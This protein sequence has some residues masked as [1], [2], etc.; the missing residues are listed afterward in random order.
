[1]KPTDEDVVVMDN[2]RPHTWSKARRL[3]LCTAASVVVLC[4][5]CRVLTNRLVTLETQRAPRDPETGI[6]VGAEPRD[7][8]PADADLAVLLVHGF[9]GA[10]NNF[11]DLPDRLAA[12]GWRV[13]VMLLPGHGTSPRDLEQTTADELLDAVLTE[14][15]TLHARHTRVALIGHSMGGTLCTLAAAQT[16]VDGLVLAAPYFGVTYRWYYLLP[17]ETWSTLTSPMV[18]W[19]R[20][21]KWLVQV[22]RKEVK[23]QIVS[24]TWTPARGTQTLIEMGR[25]AGNPEILDD[26]TCPVLLVQS[27]GDLAA[28]PKASAKAFEQIGATNKRAVWL[29]RSNHILFWDFDRDRVAEEIIAFLT[30]LDTP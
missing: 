10:G 7:L 22:N 8:G 20:K 2:T 26:V 14:F 11:N 16:H 1:M 21:S 23:D 15:E 28:S 5:G 9:V 30:S 25:R 18:R 13:R 19:V 17:A 24:Y 4:F 6:L 27:H 29:D 12:H 3:L